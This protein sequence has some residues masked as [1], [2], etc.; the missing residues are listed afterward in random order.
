[1]H[2]GARFQ[3]EVVQGAIIILTAAGDGGGKHG[4][5]DVH[6][7]VHGLISEQLR[8]VGW[9]AAVVPGA[10]GSRE[11]KRFWDINWY[12]Q[13]RPQFSHPSAVAAMQEEAAA[14][15][16]EEDAH[17]RASANEGTHHLSLSV[18]SLWLSLGVQTGEGG[19]CFGCRWVSDAPLPPEAPFY[20]RLLE[21]EEPNCKPLAPVNQPISRYANQKRIYSCKT[22]IIKEDSL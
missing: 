11:I 14:G 18:C 17:R 21:E 8:D 15:Q 22:R 16:D 6:L 12:D 1:M 20:V 13:P 4:G 5:G 3:K 7:W 19:V 10:G 9:A 2:Y